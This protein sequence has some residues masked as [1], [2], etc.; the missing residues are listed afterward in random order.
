MKRKANA[1]LEKQYKE[2]GSCCIY[3]KTA[4][5]FE[6]ITR[7]HLYPKSKGFT[8]IENKVFACLKCNMCKG[9]LSIEEFRQKITKTID[10][11]LEKVAANNWK[12]SISS[13]KKVNNYLMIT[14]NLTEII[15]NGGKP[16]ILFT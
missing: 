15:E 5:P 10:T 9:N 12:L 14:K 1:I 6:H 4:V 16:K 3:C 13:I 2:Q 11:I 7:D 8:L